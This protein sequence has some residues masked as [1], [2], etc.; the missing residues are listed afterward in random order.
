VSYVVEQ[1]VVFADWHAGL[2]DISA[3][4]II[5]RRIDRL[6]RGLFGDVKSVGGSLADAL[7]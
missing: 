7:E 4:A 5:A 3:R 1:T 6:Q 2:A